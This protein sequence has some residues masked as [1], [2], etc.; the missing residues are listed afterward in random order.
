MYGKLDEPD[1][2]FVQEAT[3]SRPYEDVIREVVTTLDLT[4]EEYS[5]PN[6]DVSFEYHLSRDDESWALELSMV[7]P[8]AAVARIGDG[9]D[10]ILVQSDPNLS[11]LERQL[12]A[13]LR[14]HNLQILSKEELEQP[15]PLRLFNTDPGN[16]R[17]YQAL[18]SDIDILPWE[19]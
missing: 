18:F 14:S 8:F 19:Q 17:V 5:D 7:G 9:W 16:V 6:D 10:S 3:D 15:V 12:L 13:I 1:F 2:S 4:Y 11:E